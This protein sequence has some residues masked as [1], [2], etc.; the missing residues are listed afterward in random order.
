MVIRVTRRRQ[1]ANTTHPCSIDY[2]IYTFLIIHYGQKPY[3]SISFFGLLY[4][5]NQCSNSLPHL[6]YQIQLKKKKKNIWGYPQATFVHYYLI[7]GA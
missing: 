7:V 1:L 3:N 5:K 6:M 2:I 4:E